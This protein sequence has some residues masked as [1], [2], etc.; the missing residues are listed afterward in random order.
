[1]VNYNTTNSNLTRGICN[2]SKKISKGL[3]RP[4]MKF[5]SDMLYGILASGSSLITEIARNLNENIPLIKTVNRLCR[6]LQDFSDEE[7]SIV[8]ENY[9]SSIKS[10]YDDKSVIVIDGSD[11][12]R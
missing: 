9:L 12:V 4:K 1:M 6:N 11:T 7:K 10:S 5:V 2:F 3:K 8:E